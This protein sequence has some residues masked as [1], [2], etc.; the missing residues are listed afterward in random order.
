MAGNSKSSNKTVILL[1]IIIAL[2]IVAIG[3]GVAWFLLSKQPGGVGTSEPQLT[4][5]GEIPYAIDVGVVDPTKLAELVQ[6]DAD[7]EIPLYLAVNAVSSDG[8]NFKCVL[9]NPPGARY[10][11]YYDIYAD[12]EFT[13][14][15]Y[16]S[17]LLAPGAQLESFKSS[18]KFPLGETDVFAVVTT[19][20]DDHKT[21]IAQN[22]VV[23]T[24]VVA[25]D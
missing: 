5:N 6:K 16:T 12:G 17:G 1:V 15:I 21:L 23:L 13:E 9:G 25:A 8:E 20:G 22:S 14:R 2:L 4:Q 3:G 7:Q 11:M 24:L 19:V 18:K 10:D